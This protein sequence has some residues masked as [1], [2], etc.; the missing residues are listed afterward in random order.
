[1]PH[2]AVK[3]FREVFCAFPAQNPELRVRQITF[4]VICVHKLLFPKNSNRLPHFAVKKYRFADS[5]LSAD[6]F[7][8]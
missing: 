2:F 6:L 1:L 5:S 7:I 4:L 8:L 3:L